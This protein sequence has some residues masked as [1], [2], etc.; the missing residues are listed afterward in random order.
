MDLRSLRYFCE[1]AACLSFSRAAERLNRSQPALSRCIHELEEEMGLRLF[2][3][4]GRS[5]TLTSAGWDLLQSA[6]TLLEHSEAF[7]ERVRALATGGTA[8]LR[9]GGAA[10]VMQWILPEILKRYGRRWPK[11]ETYLFQNGG[12]ALLAAV[13]NGE[14]DVAITRFTLSDTLDS[15]V[16]FPAHVVAVI[17]K[18]HRLASRR[19]I[20]VAELSDERMLVAPPGA[21]SRA[22]FD[23]A[24]AEARVKTRIILAGHELN[25]LVALAAAGV[26][27]AVVPS[28]VN[29]RALDVR[30]VALRDRGH[31]LGSWTSL[32]WDRRRSLPAHV[33][34]FMSE[35]SRHLARDYPGHDL[36]LP[37][38]PGPRP[39]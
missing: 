11:V 37:P 14:V 28:A 19:S 35:A 22:L 10:S 26:G 20:D 12:H 23:Q 29:A 17:P 32:V 36:N 5:V 39:A 18:G 7:N 1:I 2:E 6:R 3:R 33:R 15:K 30:V 31:H 9:I 27:I 8:I 13:D 4:T 21:T 34:G 38:L 25:V 24:C 16:L